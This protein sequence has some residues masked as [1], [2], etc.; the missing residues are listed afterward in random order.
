M[1]GSHRLERTSRAAVRQARRKRTRRRQ[2]LFGI[3]VVLALLIGGAAYV[4][5]AGTRDKGGPA[6]QAG[7]AGADDQRGD[8]TMLAKDTFLLDADG[9]KKL[10]GGPWQVSTTNEGVQVPERS[11]TCQAQRFA[12][13]AGI[14]TWVRQFKNGDS[15]A[16][17]Y[18][19]LSLDS[20]TAA[21]AYD[22]VLNWLATCTTP[23]QRLVT[24]Y[25][26]DG[27]GDRG[28]VAVFAQ[29]V[30][31]GKERYR[32]L[33]VT[34]TG[35]AMMVLEYITVASGTPKTTGPVAAGTDAMMRLC[36]ETKSTCPRSQVLTPSLLPA[37][38]EPAGFMTAIDLPVL[39][40]VKEPW[41]GVDAGT[42]PQTDCG[43]TN[44]PTA[45]PVRTA[46][47]TYLP[48][49]AKVPTEFGMDTKIFEFSSAKVAGQY[50]AGMRTTMAKCNASHSNV[51]TRRSATVGGEAGVTGQTWVVRIGLA[52]GS[53]LTYRVGAA[54][55]GK[56]V[57]YLLFLSLNGLDVTDQEFA[58][59]VARAAHRSMSY[60]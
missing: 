18:V 47:R 30:G 17:E 44:Q 36:S 13:P 45:K 6:A 33:T 48:V 23:Q 38:G 49:G 12:D 8:S 34:G 3:V 16:I 35:P 10:S 25:T 29:P 26:A 39:S 37:V 54:Q 40:K 60:K 7:N 55:A 20:R 24:S 11:F 56:R 19:E 52:N 28:T 42:N 43:E 4:V 21:K 57:T 27:L 53:N 41:V 59:T 2:Q 15:T 1:T 31:G 58:T 14:R 9:A 32:T 50:L 51:T 46:A 5:W 22:T